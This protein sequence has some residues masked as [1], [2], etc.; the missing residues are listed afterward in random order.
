MNFKKVFEKEYRNKLI[1]NPNYGETVFILEMFSLSAPKGTNDIR[2]ELESEQV[3][4][5]RKIQNRMG[6]T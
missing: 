3:R 6:N 1:L 2:A 5:C 4:S